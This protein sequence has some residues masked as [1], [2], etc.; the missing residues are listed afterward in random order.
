[1]EIKESRTLKIMYSH[2][3]N[4]NCINPPSDKKWEIQITKGN[5]MYIDVGWH[6]GRILYCPFCG[7]SANEIIKEYNRVTAAGC[8][9]KKKKLNCP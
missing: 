1:M 3:H 8:Y 4:I 5:R 2:K 6:K 9:A 7:K